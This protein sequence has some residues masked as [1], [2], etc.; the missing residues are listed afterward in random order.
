M[1]EDAKILA[2]NLMLES[3]STPRSGFWK[4]YVITAPGYRVMTPVS[5]TMAVGAGFIVGML[6]GLLVS[7]LTPAGWAVW[8]I[9]VGPFAGFGY[10]KL[11]NRLIGTD[12]LIA[13]GKAVR[14]AQGERS[15]LVI[16]AAKRNAPAYF[17]AAKHAAAL[18]DIEKRLKDKGLGSAE[19]AVLTDELDE[20]TEELR[21]IL[22]QAS[23]VHAAALLDPSDPAIRA[24]G[25]MTAAMYAEL[26]EGKAASYDESS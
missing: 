22:T 13:R 23:L 20:G 4:E 16:A 1:A 24:A 18:D 21:L 7:S 15:T 2:P 5:T 25:H 12:G 26:Q 14:V 8:L 10:A 9:A 11:V 3:F 17:A 19:R 6:V